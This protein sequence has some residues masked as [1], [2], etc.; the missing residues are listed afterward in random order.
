ML[1]YHSSIVRAVFIGSV[2]A[3]AMAS[4]SKQLPPGGHNNF[5][6]YAVRHA[7]MHFEYFGDT[8]GTE[9]LFIDSFGT[10]E[11]HDAH[12]ELLDPRGFRPTFTFSVKHGAEIINIDS[13]HHKAY[14]IVDHVLDSLSHLSPGDVPSSEQEFASY[15]GAQGYALQGDTT[16]LGLHAHVWK[17]TMGPQYLIEW[18]GLVIGKT[19]GSG[20][21]GHELRLISIDTVNPIDPR[22]FVPPSSYPIEQAPPRPETQ[23]TN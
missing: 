14:H 20:N 19:E 10:V 21:H 4:C 7:A 16:V 6:P 18:G 1:K 3:L 2:F 13:M 11:A 15:F 9:D 23:S 5:H 12:F 22:R 8:R 17:F